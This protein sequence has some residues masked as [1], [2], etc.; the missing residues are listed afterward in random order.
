M[1][2]N[3]TFDLAKFKGKLTIKASYILD[4]KKST[5]CNLIGFE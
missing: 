4:L 2:S 3:L 5:F 1:Q